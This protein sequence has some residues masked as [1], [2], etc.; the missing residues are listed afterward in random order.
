MALP[1]TPT[2]ADYLAF[3]RSTGITPAAL[4]DAS[5]SIQTSYDLAFA[6][7]NP[8]FASVVPELYVVAGYNLGVDILYNIAQDTPPSTFFADARKAWNIY[9]FVAGVVNSASDQGT[10]D[11]LVVPDFFSQLTFSDLQ[12]LKTPWGRAYLALAQKWGPDLFGIT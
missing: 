11:G 6:T 10:S 5:P 9:G 8:Y 4:P 3:I 2:L 7:V 1:T 12:N